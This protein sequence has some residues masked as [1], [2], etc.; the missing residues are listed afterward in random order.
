MSDA[1]TVFRTLSGSLGERLKRIPDG[2]TG[3]RSHWIGYQ[4]P[5]FKSNAAFER[6]VADT[7]AR[8]QLPAELQRRDWTL[9]SGVAANSL[10]FGSL[11][12][13]D[14]ALTSYTTFARLKA[15]GVIPPTCRFQVSLPTPFAPVVCWVVQHDQAAVLPAYA[16]RLL[17]E[18]DTITSA[19]PSDQLAIQWDVAVEIGVLEG[20]FPTGFVNVEALIFGWLTTLGNVVRPSVELGYHLCY[21]MYQR[22]HMLEPRD[23]AM[24]VNVANRISAAVQRPLQ[25]IHMPVPPARSDDAYFAPL[26]DLRLHAETELYLGLVHESDGEAGTRKR[27]R[28]AE[29]LVQRFGIASECGLGWEPAESLIPLFRLYA[30]CADAPAGRAPIA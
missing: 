5:V 1:E 26:A 10:S 7:A 22:R 17:T 18:L 11:G 12:Y 27:M 6:T 8:A 25:Y 14:A 28:A 2:E 15:E 23:T 20:L 16:T 30:A 24:L 9:K 19:I 13:A 4:Y 21:G 29:R 3:P